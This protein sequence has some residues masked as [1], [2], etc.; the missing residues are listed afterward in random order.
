[1][2]FFLFRYGFGGQGDLFQSFLHPRNAQG[3]LHPPCIVP[4]S[5]ISIK[6]PGIVCKLDGHRCTNVQGSPEILPNCRGKKPPRPRLRN[7]PNHHSQHAG[8]IVP[9]RRLR[10]EG[11]RWPVVPL[12]RLRREGTRWPIVPLWRLRRRD[13]CCPRGSWPWAHVDP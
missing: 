10:R 9:S 5:C 2:N 3:V 8:S 6:A 12:W 4:R 13:A 1:M 11:T 7:Q